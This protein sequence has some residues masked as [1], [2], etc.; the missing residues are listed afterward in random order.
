M[1]GRIIVVGSLNMDM[2]VNSSKIPVIGETVLG[3]EFMM[4]PG[5]KGANQAVA[6]ARLGGIVT[7]AGCVGNDIFGRH[8]VMNL[9]SNDIDTE[10][11]E[12]IDGASTGVAAI[13]VV[14]GDNCI[15]VAPGANSKLSCDMIEALEDKIK[16]ASILV[17]QLEI[18]IETVRKVIGIANKYNVRVLL[19]P[20][21]AVKLDDEFFSRVDIITPNES[22]CEIITGFTMDSIDD[23]KT[24]VSYL[25]REGV[26]QVII[27]LGDK[28]V[29]YNRGCDIIHKPASSVKVVDTTAAGD[30][31]TGAIAFALSEG[32][33]IDSAVDFAN[34][35]GALT[36]TKRGAQ[37]SLP[38]ID[39]VNKF[40]NKSS[41]K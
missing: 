4:V 11:I 6:A 7:M 26:Q 40:I 31:F 14:D 8:L 23:F 9:S 19:N 5:G 12:V 27:T 16:Q 39:D 1:S 25:N 32:K 29:V 17:V 20:A 3:S 15:I 30:A 41:A 33:D 22:E 38:Y 2:V 24:A 21:P 37:T 34:I 36:V 18:P 13:T 10:S 28:G 35:V